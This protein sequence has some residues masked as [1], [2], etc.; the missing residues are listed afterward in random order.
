MAQRQF[1]KKGIVKKITFKIQSLPSNITRLLA[2]S[3]GRLAFVM[4][5]QCVLCSAG[6]EVLCHVSEVW[7]LMAYSV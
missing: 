6:T 2:Y 5:M 7:A 1:Q 4:D 3:I